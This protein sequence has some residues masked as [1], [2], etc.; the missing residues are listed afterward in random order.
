M[1]RSDEPAPTEED[2][3]SETTL[4]VDEFVG[5]PPAGDTSPGDFKSSD[6][7]ASTT[8]GRHVREP[9]QDDR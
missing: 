8:T 5:E 3:M 2:E 6:Q 1:S 4:D 9:D 7:S